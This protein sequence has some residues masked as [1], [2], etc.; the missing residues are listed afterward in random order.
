MATMEENASLS[1]DV[2]NDVTTSS[3]KDDDDLQLYLANIRD[4]AL[5]IVYITI[6]TVGVVDNVFVLVIFVL[7]IKIT[8][9]VL[10]IF[11]TSPSQSYLRRATLQSLLVTMRRLK[12]TSKT[13]PPFGDHHPHL[14]HPSVN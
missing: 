4:T 1:S 9:K 7:F 11:K 12:F 3:S 10:A 13:A 5:K 2:W 6:G 14:I 8:D